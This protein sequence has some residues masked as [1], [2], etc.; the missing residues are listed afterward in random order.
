M[1]I[2]YMVVGMHCD[3]CAQKIKSKLSQLD[4]IN[5]IKISVSENSLI[6]TT[7][8]VYTISELNSKLSELGEG[9]RLIEGRVTGSTKLVNNIKLFM[10]LISIFTVILLITTVSQFYSTSFNWHDSMRVYM[11]TFFII[12]S[13]LKL[14]NLKGFAVAYRGYDLIAKKYE[15]YGFIYPFI[16]LGLGLMYLFSFELFFANILT[17]AVMTV[18]TLGV[19]KALRSGKEIQCACVGTFFKLPMTKVT[20][21]ENSVMILMAA[22]SLM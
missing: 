13:L 5:N 3:K 20:F 22:V 6:L 18:G 19:V 8:I 16:E 4:G 12:F 2:E 9:Y 17:I 11:A 1:V 7:H 15:G 10:P 14:V 21:I